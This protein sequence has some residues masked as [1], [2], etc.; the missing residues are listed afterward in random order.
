MRDYQIISLI[1][2]F[3]LYLI[4][5][6]PVWVLLFKKNMHSTKKYFIKNNSLLIFIEI[7]IFFIIYVFSKEIITIF[8]PKQN[9]RNYM[10][11]SFKI[12]FI[13][14]PLTVLH[15]SI[16]YFIFLNNKKTGIFLWT[17]KL[18]YIPVIIISYLILNKTINVH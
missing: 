3:L 10:S 7:I 9:I 4:S 12:L 5:F 17:L 18:S 14:S 15:Y 11:Y 1:K 6:T 8:S 2:I 16:P 13:A